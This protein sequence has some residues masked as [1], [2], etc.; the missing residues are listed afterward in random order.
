MVVAEV[1]VE[2]LQL[3]SGWQSCGVAAFGRR[4]RSL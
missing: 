3:A 2:I 4:R 1:D